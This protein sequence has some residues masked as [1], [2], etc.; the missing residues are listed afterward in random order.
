[1]RL[2]NL[3]RHESARVQDNPALLAAAPRELRARL[4]RASEAFERT[5]RRHGR[6]LYAARTVTE[7][8]VRAIADE[9]VKTR[10]AGAAYGPGACRPLGDATA[11]TLNRRA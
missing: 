10:A 8:I 9:V 1:V 6:A 2:A 4:A 11:V 5:L 7:G 3:Y